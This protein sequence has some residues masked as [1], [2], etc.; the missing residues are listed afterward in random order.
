MGSAAEMILLKANFY[1]SY[2]WRM[3][4]IHPLLSHFVR[5]SVFSIL[6]RVLVS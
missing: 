2:Y 1:I 4:L 5:K 3:D 6:K